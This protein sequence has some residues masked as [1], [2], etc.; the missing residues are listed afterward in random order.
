MSIYSLDCQGFGTDLEPVCCSMSSSNCCFLTCI[1]ISQEAQLIYKVVLVSGVQESE[2]VIYPLLFRL[3]S[4]MGHHRERLESPVL[5]SQPLFVFFFRNSSMHV[6]L[7]VSHF[8]PPPNLLTIS[9]HKFV[10]CT[11]DSFLLQNKFICIFF[12]LD[13]IFKQY[14]ILSLSIWLHSVW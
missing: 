3:L 11:C 14:P 12:F 4:H 6:S 10:F 2:S 7:S 5:G 8:I 9:N 13:S 1:Q